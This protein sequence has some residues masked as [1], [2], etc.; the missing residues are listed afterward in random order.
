MVSAAIREGLDRLMAYPAYYL[1]V[2]S[3]FQL[4]YF[5]GKAT[6]IEADR[7]QFYIGVLG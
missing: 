6:R 7:G 4:I 2:I 5:L 1:S 3:L